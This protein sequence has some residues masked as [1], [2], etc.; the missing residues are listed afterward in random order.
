MDTTY[1]YFSVPVKDTYTKG[2][3]VKNSGK[4]YVCIRVDRPPKGSEDYTYEATLSFCSPFD[5][6]S[7]KLGRKIADSLASP[8]LP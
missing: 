6:F 5:Q 7:K 8:F 1:G 3:K 4:G 2:R